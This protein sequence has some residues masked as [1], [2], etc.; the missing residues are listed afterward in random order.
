[1]SRKVDKIGIGMGKRELIPVSKRSQ[2]NPPGEKLNVAKKRITKKVDV[3][4]NG[5]RL[6]KLSQVSSLLSNCDKDVRD[7]IL[8][9]VS[10]KGK[11]TDLSSCE[12]ERAIGIL[13]NVLQEMKTE[14]PDHFNILKKM[15]L[16]INLYS[17]DEWPFGGRGV[18]LYWSDWNTMAISSISDISA[19]D[20]VDDSNGSV[21]YHELIH[22]VDDGK[23][24]GGLIGDYASFSYP[25]LSKKIK[26]Y[27]GKAFGERKLDISELYGI[28]DN[29]EF[30]AWACMFLKYGTQKQQ[31]LIKN[32]KELME[33]IKMWENIKPH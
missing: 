25:E 20:S 24:W 1:M 16:R 14:K 19:V 30:I 33:I 26:N 27:S 32:D 9:K 17:I 28:D 5:S 6:T 4:K 21:Y 29:A 8:N 31:E 2:I 13:K 23:K 11:K 7:L 22:A 18:G 15:P 10:I 12:T 3:E